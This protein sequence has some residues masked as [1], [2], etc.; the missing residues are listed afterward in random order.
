MTPP[1]L[2][3]A[4]IM[5][6]E[7]SF[8]IHTLDSSFLLLLFLIVVEREFLVQDDVCEQTS[9]NEYQTEENVPIKVLVEQISEN[10]CTKNKKKRTQKCEADA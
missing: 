8:L 4:V 6:C 10:E 1:F 9:D 7:A 2:C 5:G 3:A